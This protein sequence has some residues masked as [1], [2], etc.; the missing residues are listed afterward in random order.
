MSNMSTK[1]TLVQKDSDIKTV[2]ML[3]KEIWMEHYTPIIGAAQV[4]YMLGKFQS[5]EAV[6]SQISEGVEYYLAEYENTYSGYT[7]LIF[8][9]EEYSMKISK[10]YILNSL[11]GKGLGTAILNY[12]EQRCHFKDITTIWLTVNKYNHDS[13]SWYKNRGF[14]VI[15][16]EKADIGNGY[17]MDDYIMQKHI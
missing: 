13:I 15:R 10:L 14:K 17:Y 1:I 8:N 12:I 2:S 6:K 5:C 11:R 4:E 7:A 3:A 16:E 9:S